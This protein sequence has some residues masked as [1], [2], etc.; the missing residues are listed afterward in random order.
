M[1]ESEEL[2][3]KAFHS[4]TMLMAISTLEDGCII[5]VNDRYVQTLGYQKEELIGKTSRELQIFKDKNQ[6]PDILQKIKKTGFV[7]DIEFPFVTKHNKVRVGLFSAEI[8][9]LQNKKCL[10]TVM[11]DI[12][13]RVQKDEELRS[14]KL[15]LEAVYNKQK[16]HNEILEDKVKKRTSELEAMNAALKVLLKKRN[17]DKLELEEN[18]FSNYK[19]LIL[20]LIDKIKNA[21]SKKKQQDL[22]NIL[23]SDLENIITPFSKKLSNPLLNL[24]PTEI[25]IADL[26]KFG[27]T[28]KEIA[29]ILNSSIHT[30][31]CHREKIR[32]KLRLKGKKINL[33]KFLSSP[34][35]NYIH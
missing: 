1:K 28:N 14:H 24:S 33:K 4:N 30:I 22:I 9:H 27:K 6:R 18:I 31:S 3:S 25:I 8:I 35:N 11:N 2:F 34:F 12:T 10:L 13:E 16:D 26:I 17:K 29:E 5:D 23:E 20:P 7:R 15:Q 32:K 21:H 19:Q